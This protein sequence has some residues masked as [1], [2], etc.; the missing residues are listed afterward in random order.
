MSSISEIYRVRQRAIEYAIKHNNNSK[1]A[2]KYKTSRQQIKRWRDRYDGT[3]QSLLPKSRRPKSH[4]N[5]H[6]QEEVG[7]VMKKYRKFGYEGLAEVYVKARK[8]GY[9]RTYD[10]MCKII[11][12]MKGNAKEKPKKLHKRKKKVEQAKY[13]GERVQ[14]DIKYVP[15]ECIQFGTRD[16]KY[17]QITALDEYTRKRVLRIADE[18][19]TYQT[20]KFLENLEREQGFDIKKVQTDNGKEFTNSESDKKTLFELKLE[21]KGME[22]VTTR[23]YSPWENGKVERSHRLDSKYYADKKFKSK[24]EL[25]RAIRK[26][27]TRYNNISRKVLG[28]KSPNE[29]L[30]E[31][32]QNQ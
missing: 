26:Y 13:P 30:K 22:Y 8:E 23:P 25:L 29:V 20:A 18:K 27:N 9:S 2:V 14:I 1:A 4:P 3:V 17:Y 15:E 5:Q 19:S 28:F 10:S 32:K 12:K 6:T 24:E 16:Q 7:M 31:Y 11:R 21:E